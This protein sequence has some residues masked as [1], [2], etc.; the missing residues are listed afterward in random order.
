MMKKNFLLF[1][2]LLL[3]VAGIGV[4][5]FL[6]F[7]A[8]NPVVP[9]LVNVNFFG[10][11]GDYYLG[12][13]PPN[14]NPDQPVLV[15]V[16][17][18]T[19]DAASWWGSTRYN[20]D[21]DMYQCAYN[22]GYR[23]AFVNFR[24]ADGDAGDMWRNGPVLSKQLESICKHFNVAK[25]NLIC[26]S[27]GG[28]DSQ[29]AIVY[30]GASQ[31]VARIFTLSTPHWGSPLADLA[32]SSWVSWL[33]ELIGMQSDGTYSLQTGYMSYF[34]SI[35][36]KNV[37]NDNVAYFTAAGTDWGPKLSSL[38]LGGVYLSSYGDN[39][40][41]VT[42]ESAHNPRAVHVITGKFNHDGIRVGRMTWKYI[43]PIINSLQRPRQ[44]PELINDP[45]DHQGLTAANIY[46]RG[47]ALQSAAA[48]E[49][50]VDSLT[51]RIN[52]DFLVAEPLAKIK[53]KAPNGL[54]YRPVKVYRD[55]DFFKGATHHVF[56]IN[57]PV[58]GNWQVV[59][60]S[61]TNNAYFL[62]VTY[63][64]PLK[65]KLNIGKQ[66][67]KTNS[68]YDFKVAID[69]GK[70]EVKT[71]NITSGVQL[72]RVGSQK[73]GKAVADIRMNLK[74]NSLERELVLPSEPGLY[75][76]CMDVKGTL[77]DGS[78]FARSLV[79]SFMVESERQK[80][81]DLLQSLSAASR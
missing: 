50:P 36:D 8:A 39:D 28:I 69:F 45:S 59:V 12:A 22:A 41:A 43:E 35:T 1:L 47:G 81:V 15:F 7:A 51:R 42:V 53:I 57:R 30:Y 16:Q 25:V 74:D 55:T 18:L 3:V 48:L 75:N 70:S 46:A 71:Y 38:H 63:D 9:T 79:Y 17:G 31:Y 32:Y 61:K 21:N 77:D 44:Q 13:I 58:K 10:S 26:H 11:E 80:G 5:R 76:L 65:L 37:A 67:A 60:K 2:L 27:K 52:V 24:D 20:G 66:C 34:R 4:N 64:S 72:N 56:I 78:P 40:G 6:L 33:S 14:F 19:S 23:T 49:I 68:S 29:A 73:G 62:A 54:S